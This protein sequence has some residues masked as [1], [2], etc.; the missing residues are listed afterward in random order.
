[1]RKLDVS[2]PVNR[3]EGDGKDSK[4]RTP[5]A[6]KAALIATIAGVS[7]ILSCAP[8][9]NIKYQ[10]F[11][12]NEPDAA[13]AACIGT[14][15]KSAGI[16]REKS[17]T[18]G[19]NEMS[20]GGAKLTFNGLVDEGSAKAA[21]FELAGCDGAKKSDSIKPGEDTIFTLSNNGGTSESVRV[22]VKTMAYD[23]AGLLI[24][25]EAKPLCGDE[26][27]G[28]GGAGGSAGASN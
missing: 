20:V 5:F 27:G 3:T 25:V 4:A 28:A 22:T 6:A 17:N 18:A 26:D 9:V 23:G 21:K 19:T 10:G 15:E 7:G 2:G 12:P 8:D 16:L 14:C 1:L 13:P 24:E 11:D